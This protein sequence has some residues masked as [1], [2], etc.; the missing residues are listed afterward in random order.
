M[1]DISDELALPFL[2]RMPA[3][4][5]ELAEFLGVSKYMTHKLIRELRK[6]YTIFCVFDGEWKYEWDH[7]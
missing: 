7:E 2:R 1:I 4:I 6:T 5:S 3:T